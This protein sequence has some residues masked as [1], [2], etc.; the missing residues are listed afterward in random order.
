MSSTDLVKQ[1]ETLGFLK[2]RPLI[3]YAFATTMFVSALMLFSVQPMFAKMVVPKLGGSPSVWAVAMCFFQAVLLMGYCYAHLLT[4]FLGSRTAIFTHLGVC[5]MAFAFLPLGLATGWETPPTENTQIWLLG[6]FF[7][8]VGWPF[9]AVSAN[10]PLLQAWFA[11]TGHP[12]AGDPYFLYG[13][14]N[15]GSMVA[16]LGYPIIIEPIFGLSDQS[17]TWAAG[18]ALLISLISLAAILLLSNETNDATEGK[19]AVSAPAI[20]APTWSDRAIWIALAFIPSGLLVAFTTHITTDVASAPFLW[21][22]PLTLYLLTYIL[23]FRDPPKPSMSLLLKLQPICVGAALISLLGSGVLVWVVGA[24][25]GVGAFFTTAMICHRTLYERR[26]DVA[27]LT[28]FY[29]WMS[30]GGVLGGIFTALLAPV[31][32][33]QVVEYPLLM[34]MGLICRKDALNSPMVK[35]IIARPLMALSVGIAAFAFSQLI[36]TFTTS[37]GSELSRALAVAIVMTLASGAWFGGRQLMAGICTCLAGL[38]LLPS[39]STSEHVER[40]FF[41]VHRILD[42]ENSGYRLLSHGTT[43]HGAQ[44]LNELGADTVRPTPVTYYNDNGPMAQM[45]MLARRNLV[46][47]QKLTGGVVGLGAGS[48]ACHQQAGESWRFYEIDP[49]VVKLAKSPE[50]YSFM[51]KCNPDAEVVI[52]DA[53]LTVS[54]EPAGKFDYLLIDAFSSDTVPVHLMTVEAVTEFL[55]RV[56]DNG[57][58]VMHISNRYLDLAPVLEAAVAQ[59]GGTVSG[60]MIRDK[61]RIGNFERAPS[62]VVAISKSSASLENIGKWDEVHRFGPAKVKPWTDDYSNIVT[63]IFRKIGKD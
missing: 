35:S 25:A 38:L 22:V 40:S 62:M 60:A 26:P 2:S 52:G 32:F 19:K 58:L 39:D 55:S 33:S 8:S 45:A 46:S 5:L 6:L 30:F 7:M 17:V 51:S 9:F 29:L 54:Q 41:G 53:R 50:H 42:D 16:L 34:I 63:A 28:E 59:I 43:I 14:S 48:F 56:S 44:K 13:A 4:R 57:L 24:V 15:I 21:I 27:H 12:H 61:T 1:S 20:A 47:G 23:V 11:R 36:G 10:A 18:F 3:L 49:V 31:L 37:A